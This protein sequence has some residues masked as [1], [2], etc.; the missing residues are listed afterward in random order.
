MKRILLLRHAKS[1]QGPEYDVDVD[2]PLAKRGKRDAA[3][4][5][6]FLAERDI[7]PDLVLSSPATRAKETAE[8]YADAAGYEGEIRIAPSLYFEGDEAYLE[9]LA[10]LDDFIGTAMLVGHNPDISEAIAA[11]SGQWVRMPTAALACVEFQ[12]DRWAELVPGEGKLAWV[13]VPKE[14]P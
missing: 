8:R 7:V 6:Q 13:Q 14:L 1:K 12:G 4:V 5:G 3:R 9:Q 2:R 11:L 10:N